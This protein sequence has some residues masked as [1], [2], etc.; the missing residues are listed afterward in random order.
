[1]TYFFSIELKRNMSTRNIYFL[2]HYRE[3]GYTAYA[4]GSNIFSIPKFH[5]VEIVRYYPHPSIHLT[6]HLATLQEV[7]R[8]RRA[9]RRWLFHP[10]QQLYCKIEGHYPVYPKKFHSTNLERGP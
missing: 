8:R 10:T 3:R 7:F 1:M 5:E 9:Y 2:I 6:R 4:T